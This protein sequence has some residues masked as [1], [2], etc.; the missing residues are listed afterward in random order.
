MLVCWR[1]WAGDI[2]LILHSDFSMADTFHE[3]AVLMVTLT[4]SLSSCRW[5]A[6]CLPHCHTC[7][8][9]HEEKKTIL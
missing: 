2:R 1:N 6:Q 8:R 3:R 4:R 7:H 9:K 5:G